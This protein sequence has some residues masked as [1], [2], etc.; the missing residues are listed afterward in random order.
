MKLTF[1]TSHI[2]IHIH[3]IAPLFSQTH[4]SHVNINKKERKH[5]RFIA[6]QVITGSNSHQKTI[7][8]FFYITKKS[9][10]AGKN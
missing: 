3:I 7:A 6:F 2:V 1:K 9:N 5:K 4:F 10:C 8:N